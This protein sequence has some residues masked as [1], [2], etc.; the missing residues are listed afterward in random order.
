MRY[1]EFIEAMQS[2]SKT[3]LAADA[4]KCAES[5]GKIEIEIAKLRDKCE[6][7]LSYENRLR[8]KAEAL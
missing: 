6:V 4:N 5:R 7:Q 3:W 1:Q 8:E 2:S